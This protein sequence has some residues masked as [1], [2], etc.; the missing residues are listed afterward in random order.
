MKLII[1]MPEEFEIHFMQDKFED[2]FIRIIGDMSRNVP[3]L[4]G[5]DE[6]EIAEMFKTAFLNSKVVNNDVNEAADYLEK[7]KERNKAI[8]D[9]K[10]AV[11]KAICIGCGYLKG[12]ECT[13]AGQNC[14]KGRP[15]WGAEQNKQYYILEILNVEKMAADEKRVGD[16]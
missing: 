1:E 16:E 11:A 10:R 3:S 4:C 5:V 9:S 8:E 6:K 12:T 13:Y 15:K 2:F 7:G 14:G